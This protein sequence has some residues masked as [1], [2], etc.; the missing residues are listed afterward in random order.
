MNSEDPIADDAILSVDEAKLAQRLRDLPL[1][2]LPPG[3]RDRISD[4][5]YSAAAHSAPEP[6]RW[7]AWRV[8]L[9]QAVAACIA[10]VALSRWTQTPRVSTAPP[11]APAASR[12][13]EAAPQRPL[14]V[15]VERERL[16]LPRRPAYRT[17]I[18]RWRVLGGP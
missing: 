8:P 17:D 3:A 13:A 12:L 11:V 16:G 1:Q 4:R 6:R 18:S 9:W 2:S 14:L 7:W 10:C 5:L 15:P